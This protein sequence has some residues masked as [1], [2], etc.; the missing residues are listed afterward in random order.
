RLD[1]HVS[2]R[3]V[4][5][6]V[7]RADLAVERDVPEVASGDADVATEMHLTGLLLRNA[8]VDVDRVQR[9][10]RD[11]CVAA[12]QVLAEVDR[13]EAEN[14]GERRVDRLP[15]DGRANLV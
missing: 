5:D 4:D 15:L 3:L 6:R 11:H 9:L 13:A 7:E 1:G 8:E 14:P 10:Q 12:V 2:R